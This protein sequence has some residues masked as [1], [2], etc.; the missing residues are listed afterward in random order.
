VNDALP[1]G[2]ETARLTAL[3]FELAAQL[4]VERAQRIA[5][6]LAL[7]Q[8]ALLRTGATRDMVALPEFR[9][10]SQAAADGAIRKLLRVATEAAIDLTDKE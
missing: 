4:H 8:A 9:V 5:L 2:L 1:R 10:R 7:E 3:V 6:E